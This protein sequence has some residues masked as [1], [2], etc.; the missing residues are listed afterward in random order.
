MTAR[1]STFAR[2]HAGLPLVV[3]AAVLTLAG[4]AQTALPPALV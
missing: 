3:V 1:R 4:E 2:I